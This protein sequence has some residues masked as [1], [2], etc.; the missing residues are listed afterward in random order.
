MRA[1]EVDSSASANTAADSLN[2]PILEEDNPPTPEPRTQAPRVEEAKLVDAEDDSVAEGP[3]IEG[4]TVDASQVAAEQPELTAPRDT[5][6][7]QLDV[8]INGK[9]IKM[10]A[11]FYLHQDGTLFS[12]RGELAQIGIAP[13]G[14]GDENDVVR[15][16]DIPSLAYEYDESEQTI[17]ITVGAAGRLKQNID[18]RGGATYRQG[19]TST[20]F[21]LNYSV[22]SA[23]GLDYGLSNVNVNGISASLDGRFFSKFGVLEMSGIVATPDFEV[24]NTTRLDTTWTYEDPKRAM[25]YRIGD[26]ISG[27]LNWTRPVRLGGGQI[28]RNFDIR[29]D[30]VTMPLPDITGSAGVP[31]TLDVY[32][33]GTKAYSRD[34]DQGPFEIDNIPVIT[35][36]GTTRVVLTDAAGRKVEA[37][38]DYFTSPDLLRPGLI[39]FSLEAGF[40]RERYGTDS[41]QYGEYPVAIGNVRAGLTN[42][43]TIEGHAEVSADLQNG[44]VGLV[45]ALPY[46]GTLS[47]AVA[48]SLH[49]GD[50]GF[51][52]YA[53]WD[54]QWNNWWLN[55]AVSHKFGDYE[56]LAS[57]NAFE[58][59]GAYSGA[60]PRAREQIS[61]G[62]SMPDY[63]IGFGASLIHIENPIGV[64]DYIVSA[65]VNK[66]IGDISLIGNAFYNFGDVNDYGVALTFSMPLGERRQVSANAIK[67]RKGY[68][69]ATEVSQSHTQE[70]YSTAWRATV[71]KTKD[72]NGNGS[73]EFKTPVGTARATVFADASGASGSAGFDGAVALTGS[74]VNLAPPLANSFAIVDAGIPGIKV[75]HE[76]R[77]IGKTGR[78]GTLLVPNLA[79]YSN[80]KFDI[81]LDDAPLA[82]ETGET[83]TFVV[84]RAKSGVRVLFKIKD[85]SRTAIVKLVSKDAA[86]LAVGTEVALDGVMESFVVG[87]DGEVFVSGLQDH[88]SLTVKLDS[89][90]CKIEFDYKGTSEE[91]GYLGP[92]TCA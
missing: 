32:I 53:S 25:E 91:Q 88:N 48:G 10:V 28:R 31:S 84:P 70:E 50:S 8:R 85:A 67:T 30:L 1:Q 24:A 34:L 72:F 26:V 80:N 43:L 65:S 76:N 16:S 2:G 36:Q 12:R 19:E 49:D 57:I 18:A 66:N 81:D 63:E 62:Y 3:I 13:A 5:V 56:D 39:D 7:L 47:A 17:D 4:P 60:V 79:P 35:N 22:F 71:A 29:P 14:E 73:G 52:L 78:N 61:A 51:L 11:A 92:L 45:A 38:G 23:V 55:A 75:K 64:R 9:D 74:G 58:L 68:A 77:V 83:E 44:G 46:M 15:L 6:E 27:G 59:T 41:F 90:T 20:G 89:G 69:A 33:G 42:L 86:P 40:L 21:V 82:A 54:K 87:H 37:E